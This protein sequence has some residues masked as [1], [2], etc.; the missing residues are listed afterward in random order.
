MPSKARWRRI[1][2]V[3]D[4]FAQR[5]LVHRQIVVAHQ[6]EPLDHVLAAIAARD[7]RRI[8]DA[9]V[10]LAAREVQ[11][12]CD[13]TA[14]LAATDHQHGPVGQRLRVSIDR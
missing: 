8:A 1:G 2:L 6:M 5:M 11:I 4:A 9:K 12:F 3:A 7:P 10:N 13:L 14:G